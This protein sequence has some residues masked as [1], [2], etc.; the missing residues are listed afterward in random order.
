MVC[1]HG[2]GGS[3]PPRSTNLLVP[4]SPSQTQR[5]FV[6]I[7]NYERLQASALADFSVGLLKC[8]ESI[9]VSDFLSLTVQVQ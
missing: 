4:V 3:T 7:G 5:S 1:N 2:V 9:D 6:T 8:F